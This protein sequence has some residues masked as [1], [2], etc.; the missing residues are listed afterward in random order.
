[1]NIA[2]AN[3]QT[4]VQQLTAPSNSQPSGSTGSGSKSSSTATSSAATGSSNSSTATVSATQVASSKAKLLEAEQQLQAAQNDLDNAELLAPISGTVGTVD[5]AAGNTASAG[6]ITIVGEGN[7]QVS[8]ELPLKTRI[9][10]KAGLRV[11]VTP[12]G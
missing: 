9:T 4:L 11:T 12:A 3:L 7:A 1:V 5:L 8:F 6:S 10:I 2:T